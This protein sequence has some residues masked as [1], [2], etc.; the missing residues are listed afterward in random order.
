[1]NDRQSPAESE[2]LPRLLKDGEQSI[3]G[4][5]I[6]AIKNAS[7]NMTRQKEKAFQRNISRTVEEALY[8]RQ[9]VDQEKARN[10]ALKLFHW[11]RRFL[12]L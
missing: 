9:L 3:G 6:I 2:I 7:P 1:M 5:R 4:K 12:H 10:K 8:K 11:L